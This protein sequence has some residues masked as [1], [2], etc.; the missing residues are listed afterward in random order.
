[1]DFTLKTKKINAVIQYNSDND[2]TLKSGSIIQP[3]S[4][5]LEAS[6]VA[7]RNANTTTNANGHLITTADLNFKSLSRLAS[8]IYGCSKNGKAVFAPYISGSA[9]TGSDP[10]QEPTEPDATTSSSTT[11]KATMLRRK[12]IVPAQASEGRPA[13]AQ[14][15]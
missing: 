8:F 3:A 14:P 13:G 10:A 11:Q 5:S 15:C 2:T 1:M 12:N 7:L 9:T 4:A 6:L